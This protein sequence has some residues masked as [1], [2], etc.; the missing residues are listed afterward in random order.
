MPGTMTVPL[1]NQVSLLFVTIILVTYHLGHSHIIQ[2]C[3]RDLILMRVCSSGTGL[4]FQGEDDSSKYLTEIC[5]LRFGFWPKIPNQVFTC[6]ESGSELVSD[7]QVGGVPESKGNTTWI[8]LHC[9]E[10]NTRWT[11]RL[12]PTYSIPIYIPL[13]LLQASS[14]SFLNRWNVLTTKHRKSPVSRNFPVSIISSQFILF[15]Q[16][17]VLRIL[18]LPGN[19]REGLFSAQCQFASKSRKNDDN[20]AVCHMSDPNPAFEINLTW[21][22]AL[23]RRE[24]E[25]GWLF[26][27]PR[28]NFGQLFYTVLP[29]FVA[30]LGLHSCVQN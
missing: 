30:L 18:R 19:G 4:V 22:E 5:W 20:T 12:S 10:Q 28:V 13:L 7:S 14:D 25:E 23:G 26:H 8:E 29:C 3:V 16:F 11:T 15:I 24:S 21:E 6:R 9:L 2:E 27:G 1:S 17:P